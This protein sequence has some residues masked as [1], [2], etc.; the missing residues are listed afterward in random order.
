M[1]R[2]S[3]TPKRVRGDDLPCIH[4]NAAGLDIGASAIVAAG[5]P[6]RDAEPVRVF[7]TFTPDLH[8]LVDGLLQCGIATVAMESTGVYWVPVFELLEHGGIQPDRVNARHVKTVP[9]RTRDWNDAQWLQKLH[10][11]GLVHAS[12]RPDAERCLV[13]TL[14]RHRAELIEHRAPHILHLHKALKLMNM[15]LSE[16]LTDLTGVTGQAIWRAIVHGERD[17]LTLAQWRNPAGKSSADDLAKALTGTWRDEQVCILPQALALFAF[18]THQLAECEARVEPQFAA[19]KPRFESDKPP[20]PLPRV[21]PGSKS[22]NQPRDDARAQLARITGVDL[23]AVTGISASMA[24]T[25]LSEVG[26]DMSQFPTVKHF[27]S[28]LGLAPHHDVSGGQVLRSRTLKGVSRA[29]QAFRQ[30]AQA[31]ARS[32]SSFGAYFHAMRARLG[33]QQAT[34]ATAHKIARVI[35][36][37]LKDREPFN[38]ASAASYERPRRE[39]ELKHLTRRA[40]KLGYMLTPVAISPPASPV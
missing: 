37:L 15:Q 31:V 5:P 40:S 21:K 9:G 29:T 26:T 11:L 25:I 38:A 17:P 14:L 19:M 6:E 32:G 39:R 28:W 33:P 20:R 34:V 35:S 16:V 22:K 23:V 27:C 3:P 24:Q 8:A 30:A 12:F 2:S 4:P 7:E 36:H 10:G 13:R 18:Y 1:K